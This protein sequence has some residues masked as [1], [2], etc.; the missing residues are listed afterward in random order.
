VF[1]EH[2]AIMVAAVLNSPAAI[3]M[4]VFVVRA[5]VT[6][7]ELTSNQRALATALARLEKR[8]TNHDSELA[9]IINLLR[10]LLQPSPGTKRKIGHSA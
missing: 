1:T 10:V 3:E 9:Q 6:M 7:R 4:S 8:V 2:G 5:F